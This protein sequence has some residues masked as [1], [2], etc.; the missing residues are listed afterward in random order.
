MGNPGGESGEGEVRSGGGGV[1]AD[2]LASGEEE[3]GADGLACGDGDDGEDCADGDGEEL[4]EEVG[5]EVMERSAFLSNFEV[6][7]TPATHSQ[8]IVLF[9]SR[10]TFALMENDPE[11]NPSWIV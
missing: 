4:L 7:L 3:L 10:T 9:R 2:G 8:S 5:V 1:C 11:A 6:S